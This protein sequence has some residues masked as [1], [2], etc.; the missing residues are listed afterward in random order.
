[1]K[2]TVQLFLIMVI[3]TMLGLSQIAEA[4]KGQT[5]SSSSSSSKSSSS[6]SSSS[7]SSSSYKSSSYS[8]PSTSSYS[9]SSSKSS[10]SIA[11]AAK[12]TQAKSAWQS[13]LKKNDT[14]VATPVQRPAPSP[15]NNSVN[16]EKQLSD[17][18]YQLKTEKNRNRSNS[19]SQRLTAIEQQIAESRRQQQMISAAQTAVQVMTTNKSSQPMINNFPRSTSAIPAVATAPA[20]INTAK[21]MQA[22]NSGSSWGLILFIIAVVVIVIIWRRSGST[23][24]THYRL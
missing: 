10:S 20:A 17:L 3:M 6:S 2:K 24:V 11:N 16:L 7:R 15:Q 14:A 1:M 19:L 21:P 22:S 23:P 5:S 8:K 13:F 12:T 4:R 9:S 18:R